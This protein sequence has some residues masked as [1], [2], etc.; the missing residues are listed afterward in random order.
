MLEIKQ[1]L[2]PTELSVLRIEDL[3]NPQPNIDL[4][5]HL[6]REVASG[7]RVP[8]VRVWRSAKPF[9][10]GVSRKDV[11]SEDGAKA[12]QTLLN[13]GISVIVRQTGGTAVPQGDGVIHLSLLFPRSAVRTT[14]DDYYRLLC[15]PLIAWFQ[16]YGLEAYT[17]P[18]PGSYCDGSYNVL[19]DGKKLIGT[20]QAWRGGLAG[21]TSS[22]PGYILAHACITVDVDWPLA[23]LWMNRFYEL[24]GDAYRVD[25]STSVS[26]R[27]L[28]P[29]RWEGLNRADAAEQ[30][31]EELQK[32]LI[33]Y[34]LDK[35]VKLT[36]GS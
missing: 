27:S 19:V 9:G 4:D 28:T 30:S 10:I 17:G 23:T 14:T 31:A 21:M 32:Y 15:D 26:L 16:S 8:L 5:A 34:Y 22:H 18:L 1:D 36:V 2:I 29:D 12:R 7:K 6:G 24:A 3:V 33:R 13:Q 11:A 25:E 20:A 35:G